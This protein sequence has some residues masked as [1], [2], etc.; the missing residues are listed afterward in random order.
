MHA[1]P[2]A[3]QLHA[4]GYAIAPDFLPG[5]TWRD[6][7]Q[8]FGTWLSQGKFRPAGIGKGPERQIQTD[9]RG[10]R[11][12]WWESATP[13]D[14]QRETRTK[15]DELRTHLNHALFLGLH[16]FEGHYAI[17]PP[18]AGYQKHRD[19]FRDDD[20]RTLSLVLYLN[21]DWRPGDGGELALYPGSPASTVIVEPRAG[22]LACFLS[23]EI[24]HE[25]RPAR[26]ER[27]SFA[28]WWKQSRP[29]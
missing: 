3:R 12:C 19:A 23:R 4:Q 16:E 11:I 2:I 27:R 29:I 6:L 5:P 28:G 7:H 22:T 18:G 8:E 9:I 13:T 21:P 26:T 10:D 24:T 15:L 1:E 25:V 20:A 17:Y 14:A